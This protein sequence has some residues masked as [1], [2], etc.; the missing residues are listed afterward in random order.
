MRNY[1]KFFLFSILIVLVSILL[2]CNDTQQITEPAVLDGGE[3]EN[4]KKR[5]CEGGESPMTED[6]D[7]GEPP[8]EYGDFGFRFNWE[9]TDNENIDQP[10]SFYT[11]SDGFDGIY[12]GWSGNLI[13]HNYE[14]NHF[15]SSNLTFTWVLDG[16]VISSGI[17]NTSV[18]FNTSN[19]NP[20]Y[21]ELFVNGFNSC[22]SYRFWVEFDF[23]EAQGS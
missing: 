7:G 2:S 13:T 1:G 3:M 10:W 15:N 8:L 11:A 12:I 18:E 9:F 16:D 6:D 21:L 4:S 14:V 19:G 5:E 22:P 17:N 20:Y 23:E